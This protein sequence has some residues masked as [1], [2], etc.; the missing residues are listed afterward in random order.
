[1]NISYDEYKK[2]LKKY[3]LTNEDITIEIESTKEIDSDQALALLSNSRVKQIKITGRESIHGGHTKS[4]LEGNFY[5]IEDYISIREEIDKVVQQVKPP[6]IGEPDREKKI[7]AQVYK[8]LG[9]M[10]SYDKYAITP[11]GEKDFQL[12]CDCRNLKNGLLGVMRNGKKERICVCAGFAE[13]LRNVLA[14]LGIDSIYVTSFPET[15]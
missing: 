14:C 2:N 5:S 13:I 12:A 8:T 10:M 7:F 4:E 6:E 3:R 9:K 15:R 1:M 11:E